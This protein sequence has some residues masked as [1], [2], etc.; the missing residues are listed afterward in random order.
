MALARVALCLLAVY[1]ASQRP[2]ARGAAGGGDRRR[3]AAQRARADARCSTRR[4]AL[5]ARGD[6]RGALRALYV[7]ALVALDRSRLIEY[8]PRKTNGQ[9]LRGMP[10]GDVRDG[11]RGVHAHLR[12]HVLRARR[13]RAPR[14]TPRAGALAERILSGVERPPRGPS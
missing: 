14:T 1:V 9:Y 7:A 8:E 10:H 5:A 2:A 13:P 12:P 11:V 6:L 3:R 4:R